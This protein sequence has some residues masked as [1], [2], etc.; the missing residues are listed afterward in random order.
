MPT[1][2]EVVTF[3]ATEASASDL[4]RI[5]EASKIRRKA[6]ASARAASVS[7]DAEVEVAGNISPK[8][9]SGLKGTVTEIRGDRGDV[10]LDEKSTQTLAYGRSKFSGVAYAAL[11]TEDKRYLLV[12]VP[13]SCCEVQ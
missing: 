4:D 5:F 3:T 8:A 12:G 11:S 10:L 1:L 9:L 6:L 7:V 13:L 2:Q